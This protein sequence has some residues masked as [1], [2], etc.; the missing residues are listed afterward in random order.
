MY[1]YF[2][3][4]KGR[5][6][7]ALREMQRAQELDPVSLPKI[8]AVGEALYD[9]RRYDEAIAAFQKALEM[10]PNS[11]F[12]YWA[13]G[14]SYTEKGMYPEAITAFKKSI[15]LSGD[16]PDEPATLAYAYA[17]SGKRAEA[18]KIITDLES[19]R[20]SKY[21][22]PTVI[23]FIYSALGE[24]DQAFAWMS[25]ALEERDFILFLRSSRRLT[26]CD[27]IRD[28]QFCGSASAWRLRRRQAFHHLEDRTESRAW[29]SPTSAN[30]GLRCGAVEHTRWMSGKES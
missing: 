13:L 2:V 27:Q 20:R 5:S 1:G 8:T 16:S 25:K 26:T 30:S 3:S 24:N 12:A 19:Q 28:S 17:L 29:H 6:D 23:A 7:E 4:S 21:V 18:R 9:A 10:D 14:R 22:A 15:P 11:G